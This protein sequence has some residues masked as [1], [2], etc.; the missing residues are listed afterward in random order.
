MSQQSPFLGI[1]AK[2]K[3]KKERKKEITILKKYLQT[4]AYCSI[5]HNNQDMKTM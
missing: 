3:K 5:I 4:H 2:Q 1:Y